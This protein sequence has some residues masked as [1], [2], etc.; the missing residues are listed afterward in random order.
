[1]PRKARKNAIIL[2]FPIHVD[3]EKAN[4]DLSY[5]EYNY[6][7]YFAVRLLSVQALNEFTLGLGVPT[8]HNVRQVQHF[9]RAAR[10]QGLAP[11]EYD[12][13]KWR[14]IAGVFIIF[15]V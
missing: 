5:Y 7:Q 4:T 13:G 11:L 14:I 6:E 3:M 10:Q 2:N 1:M 9:D 12:F 15:G 8:I